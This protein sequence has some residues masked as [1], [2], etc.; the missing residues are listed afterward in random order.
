[1]LYTSNPA[2]W[3]KNHDSAW[4]HV[5]DAMRRDWEQ[6]KYDFGLGGHH[7]DQDVDPDLKA[8]DPDRLR[9]LRH[10]LHFRDSKIL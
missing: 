8:F 4:D 9:H 2:W 1:M 10:A 3:T 7:L 6:T 5:C